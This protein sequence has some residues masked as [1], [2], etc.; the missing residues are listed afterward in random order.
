MPIL[1]KDHT[2]EQLHE[3]LAHLGVTPRQARQI[4]AAVVRLGKLPDAADCGIPGKLLEAV[5]RCTAIPRLTLLEKR[6]SP[7]DGF[8]KYLFRG[9]RASRSRR[10]G[11]RSCIGPR[12]PN[13]RL[14]QFAR[15][16]RAGLPL[17]RHRTDGISPRIWPP[18]KSSI[19]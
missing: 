16:V 11:S 18:G 10:C 7:Q 3:G 4:H 5:G 14:R 12:T 8:A 1:I 13:S 6:V 19:R 15:W 17:L 9:G 2:A